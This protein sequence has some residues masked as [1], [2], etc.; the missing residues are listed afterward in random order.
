MIDGQDEAIQQIVNIYQMHLTGMCPSG[1]PISNFLFLGPLKHAVQIAQTL[2][3][4]PRIRSRIYRILRKF[5][6]AG[7]E[8][9]LRARSRLAISR[10]QS[11]RFF[12]CCWFTIHSAQPPRLRAFSA[13]A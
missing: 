10:V 2:N 12:D 11:C 3:I 1:R 5:F 6:Q 4:T 13:L 7:S 9:L 8:R